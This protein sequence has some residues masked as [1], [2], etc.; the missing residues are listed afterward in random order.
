MKTKKILTDWKPISIDLAILSIRLVFGLSMAFAHGWVKFEKMLEG[1][2]GFKAV[3]GLPEPISLGLA[4]FAELFCSILI[5]LGVFTRFASLMLI[6][7]MAVAV[8]DVHWNDDFSKMEKA[9]LYLSAYVTILLSGPGKWSIDSLK[10]K[11]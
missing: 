5:A 1:D 9:L 4:V 6:I 3:F 8:F 11:A 2:F 7:T 10:S